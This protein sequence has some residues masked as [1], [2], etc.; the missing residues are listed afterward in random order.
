[1]TRDKHDSIAAWLWFG[2]RLRIELAIGGRPPGPESTDR[3]LETMMATICS[4]CPELHYPPG[5]T[6]YAIAR[7][8]ISN[9]LDR[10]LLRPPDRD[11]ESHRIKLVLSL[12]MCVI[13]LTAS[14][15]L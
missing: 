6:D 1:V 14:A 3:D 13:S 9:D 2:Y 5:R 4:I 8:S 10:A 12:S 15:Q 7:V 11:R